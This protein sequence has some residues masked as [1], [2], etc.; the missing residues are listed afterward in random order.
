ISA[1]GVL[2]VKASSS[3]GELAALSILYGGKT[4]FMKWDP[5][6]NIFYRNIPGVYLPT[7]EII[8]DLGSSVTVAVQPR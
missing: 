5:V 8:S 6:K 7:L 2:Q 1:T 4:Y 3:A